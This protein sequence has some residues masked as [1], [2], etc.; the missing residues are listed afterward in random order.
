MSPSLRL[1]AEMSSRLP[2][3]GAGILSL[4][5]D[6]M[7][8]LAKEIV[9]LAQNGHFNQA[10]PGTNSGNLLDS[11]LFRQTA[12]EIANRSGHRS[13]EYAI[14]SD[15]MVHHEAQTTRARIVQSLSALRRA[16]PGRPQDI[17]SRRF[18]QEFDWIMSMR[19]KAIA[20]A[21]Q[22]QKDFIAE[23]HNPLL[24]QELKLEDI[25]DAVG[26]HV[27]TVSRLVHDLAVIFP[28]TIPRDF[29]ILVPGASLM[30]LKGRYVI[31]LLSRDARYYQPTTGWLVND[32]TL[33]AILRDTYGINAQRRTVS[34]YRLWVD[35][36]LRSRRDAAETASPESG[37][38]E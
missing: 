13:P 17:F 7:E 34:K 38:E 12:S 29:A 9:E 18:L 2:P 33:G 4:A 15:L 5:A 14:A 37:M 19:G 1:A 24:L 32:E 28:D 3:G 16:Q 8:E 10:R 11:G 36:H 23:P 6:E 31:G 30:S 25:G 22:H 27:T 21:A 26:C 35:V 20:H